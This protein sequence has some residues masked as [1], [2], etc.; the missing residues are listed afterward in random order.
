MIP[1]LAG[2]PFPSKATRGSIVAVAS[3]E[4]YTVP[5]VVGTCVIDV[6]SLQQTQGAKGHAVETL[7]WAGDELW[8]WSTTGR[9]G[10]VIPEELEGWDALDNTLAKDVN[11]LDFEDDE[12]DGGVA[13]TEV[14][15]APETGNS[16]NE[17]VSGENITAGFIDN[18]G[19]GGGMTTQGET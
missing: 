15:E 8:D 4:N 18:E 9:P 13:L 7:H 5:V 14:N 2:P 17:F 10:S 12:V 6:S 19:G 1:G 3:L 16:R 11:G